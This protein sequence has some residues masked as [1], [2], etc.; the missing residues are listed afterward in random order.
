M[1]GGRSLGLGTQVREHH[2]RA[3]DGDRAGAEGRQ[4]ETVAVRSQ[5]Q[6]V[7]LIDSDTGLDGLAGDDGFCVLVSRQ[8]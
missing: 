8:L 1:D 5:S 2:A 4:L 3:V 6:S 7:S